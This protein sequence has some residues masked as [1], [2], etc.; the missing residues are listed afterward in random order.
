MYI[1]IWKG[2]NTHIPY[3]Y[4]KS[5]KIFSYL[6]YLCNAFSEN[7]EESNDKKWQNEYMKYD[8]DNS[9]VLTP[10]VM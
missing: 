9:V 3:I 7:L 6:Y 4:V 5:C 2:C 10:S 1:S 8:T